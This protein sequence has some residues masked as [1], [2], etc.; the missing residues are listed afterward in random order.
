[1]VVSQQAS[2]LRIAASKKLPVI[3]NERGGVEKGALASYGVSYPVNGRH[4]AKLVHRVLL[5]ADPS[6]VPVE[7]VDRFHLALNLKT[8]KALGLKVPGPLLARA[9]ELIE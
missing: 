5:G 9:D 8:A 6:G 4:S 3:V 1:M 2:I 7:Q